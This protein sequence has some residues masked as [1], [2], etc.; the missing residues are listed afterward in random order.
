M[1]TMTIK[2]WQENNILNA[3]KS[4]RIVIISGSRQCGKTTAAKEILTNEHIYRTLDDATLLKSAQ[5]DAEGFV[6][7]KKG[8]MVIDEIQRVP[9]LITA[10]K[11]AVDENTRYGQY[12]ITGSVNIQNLPT[13][14]ESLAGRVKKIRLRPFTQGEIIEKT[15]LFIERLK[16]KDF[17]ESNEYDKENILNLIFKGGFPEPVLHNSKKERKS[18]YRDYIDT[19]IE[20]D[21][22]D[23]SN[24][25]RHDCLK[26]LLVILS[27]YSSK[28]IDKSDI[29]SALGIS[30]QTLDSY[31]TVLENTYLVDRLHPW[32]KTD[33]ERVKKQDKIFL[34][35]TGLMS[36]LLNWK[37]EDVFLD[38]DK[39]GK[40]FETYAYNQIIAQIETNEEELSLYH[41]RDRE[42]REIDFVLE[43]EDE[44]F[45]IEIKAGST[46]K[47]EH[48][49]HMKWFK[50]NLVKNKKFT[51]IVLYTGENAVPFGE[52]FFAVPFNN[53]WD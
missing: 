14:K 30:N 28:F 20:H 3:L 24:I 38:A 22:S 53:L 27:A 32:I 13:V 8:T 44:I 17:I 41:Y 26:E 11:K 42:K 19:L 6:K 46:V 5:N 35:D 34:T 50:N 29:T 21:L 1:K 15:P 18:W 43:T 49:N 37:K 36:T 48:F 47:K 7:L 40:I 12:L 25:R 45:G 51:G 31:I 16:N 2:R 52:G 10:I 4:R 23:I 39:S 9:E 33:Y